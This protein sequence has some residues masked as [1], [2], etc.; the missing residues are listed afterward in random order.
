MSSS[1]FS[2]FAFFLIVSLIASRVN[3]IDDTDE[4]YGYWEPLHYL[5][6]G[7]G[8]QTWEYA[9]QYAIRTYA[10]IYPFVIIANTLKWLGW[11]KEAIFYSI[12]AILGTC[13]AFAQT[14]L[15]STLSRTVGMSASSNAAVLLVLAP[16]VFFASTSFLPSAA[17]MTL[18]MLSISCWLENRFLNSILW[19]TIAVLSTGWPFCGLLFLPLGIHML[20]HSYASVMYSKGTHASAIRKVLQVIFGGILSVVFVQTAVFLLD[21]HFY[22]KWTSPTINILMYNAIGGSGDEL[23]GIEPISYYIKN[24][25]LNLSVA[26]PLAAISPAVYLVSFLV[27]KRTAGTTTTDGKIRGV[28]LHVQAVIWLAILFSRPHKEERFLYPIYPLIA[29]IAGNTLD[30]ILR[31]LSGLFGAP[32][33]RTPRQKKAGKPG[34][35]AAPWVEVVKSVL[36][37]ICMLGGLMLFSARVASNYNNFSGYIKL[38]SHAHTHILSNTIT[39]T[40]GTGNNNINN[41]NNN[42]NNNNHHQ[43]QHQHEGQQALL[44]VCTGSE[45]YQ[46]P[47]HFFL[48]DCA[49]L[50]YVRDGFGGELPQ[51]FGA[52]NGTAA[53]PLQ[54]FNDLNEEVLERYVSLSQCD[55][56]VLLVDNN[57]PQQ[58]TPLRHALLNN[59]MIDGQRFNRVTSEK[60]ISSAHS[61]SALLRAF[62]IPFLSSRS[63][64]QQDYVLFEKL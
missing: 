58:E 8:M 48:P 50:Q 26:W 35:P 34:S 32:P 19:G 55:Y 56:I 12:K 53:E 54:V 5:V 6:Y 14:R 17:C 29:Y 64:K 31:I 1:D 38:W 44:N 2:L 41:N 60:V 4:T 3:H 45:W 23:Y 22:A 15:V 33:P 63:N 13:C 49:R 51:H 11:G 37:V 9:P 46:F 21:H 20:V 28:V 62:F 25:F 61:P 30:H 43:Q 42:N 39:H 52:V 40:V 10:F 18:L 27:K 47:S 36:L 57:H 16:G 59:E 7:V 24:L